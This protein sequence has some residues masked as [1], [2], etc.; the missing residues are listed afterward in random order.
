MKFLESILF[1]FG[2]YT[3]I[4]FSI[5]PFISRSL[6]TK[7]EEF[8]NST[9]LLISIVGLIYFLVF[10]ITI[11]FQLRSLQ[12]HSEIYGMKQRLFGTYWFAYWTQPA[13]YL[14]SQLLWFKKLRK[15]TLIRLFVSLSLI[16]SIQGII[17]YLTSLHR[18]YLPSSWSTP[19][20][21]QI[22]DWLWSFGIF[23]IVST[24]FHS[25]KTNKT[26]P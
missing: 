25:I 17:I 13:F 23:G 14:T 18:D 2:I 19:I 12:T 26:E 1:A 22:I 16:A 4:L 24:V 7:I 21:L 15:L 8:D 9:C 11:Y 6:K 10:F 20:S 3:I 5:K